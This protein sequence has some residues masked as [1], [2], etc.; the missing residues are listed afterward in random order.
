MTGTQL[1]FADFAKAKVAITAAPEIEAEEMNWRELAEDVYE[2][3]KSH[4]KHTESASLMNFRMFLCMPKTFS[5]SDRVRHT[6]RLIELAI[7][8]IGKGCEPRNASLSESQR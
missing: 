6:D 8:I 3:Q 4:D 5:N 7:E 1:S 2:I